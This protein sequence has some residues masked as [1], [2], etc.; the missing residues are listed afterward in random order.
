MCSV[1]QSADPNQSH[2]RASADPADAHSVDSRRLILALIILVLWSLALLFQLRSWIFPYSKTGSTEDHAAVSVIVC[3]HQ[4]GPKLPRLIAHLQAQTYQTF[5]VVI[6]NDGPNADIEDY[7]TSLVWDKLRIVPF[8]SAQ[9]VTPGKK[10]PLSAGIQSAAHPWVLVTDADCMP[11]PE[12]ISTMMGARKEGDQ[13]ILGVAPF[14]VKPGVLNLIQ[15]FDA[16]IIAIQ[17]LGA[18]LRGTAYMGVGRN[19]LYS[20]SLF[21]R[22]GGFAGHSTLMSGDDDLFV[23][24][25]VRNTRVSVSIN[26]KSFV[27]S[28]PPPSRAAWVW[29]KRRHLSAGHAYTPLAKMQT[30]AF[31]MSWLIFWCGIPILILFGIPWMIL[32]LPVGV[33]WVLFGRQAI[34]LRHDTLIPWFPLLA[35]FYC[36]MI[37]IFGVLLILKPPGRWSTS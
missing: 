1:L 2:Y 17:Y 31:A 6:V 15:R 23:Q 22:V 21:D 16:F 12:W 25:A 4:F 3:A 26:P 10:A 29:Q 5:E 14:V 37:V 33:L 19:M 11:G 30:T 36:I 32:F 9:K 13:M 34:R 8:N 28:E 27:Y 20:G 35:V 24:S 18:A 7:L